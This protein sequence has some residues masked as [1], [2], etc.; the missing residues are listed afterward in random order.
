MAAGRYSLRRSIRDTLYGKVF[1][2][3]DNHTGNVIIIKQCGLWNVENHVSVLGCH[4]KEDVHEE[5]RLHGELSV[6]AVCSPYVIKQLDVVQDDE[7]IFIIL[8]F[9]PG[10]ELFQHVQKRP[11]ITSRHSEEKSEQKEPRLHPN[12]LDAKKYMRQ[13]TLGVAYIHS[14]FIA[15]RDLSLEN[16]LLDER[17]NLKII[18]FGVAL[19]GATSQFA[20]GDWRAPEGRVGKVQYMAPEVWN[21]RVYDARLADVWSMGVVFFIL[22]VGCPPYEMPHEGD[23]RFNLIISGKVSSLLTHW[24]L[25]GIFSDSAVDLLQRMLSPEKSRIT[26]EQMLQHPFLV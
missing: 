9:V 12:E 3:K 26:I 11:K 20:K 14:K 25:H 1:L 19:G 22:L 13:L 4:V 6:D 7:N 10:G 18:D 15:H 24:K 2:G 16:L 23:P 21:G 8:E 5:I 17:E